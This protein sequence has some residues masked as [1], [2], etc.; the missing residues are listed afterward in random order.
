[1]KEKTEV[2]V[3][4]SGEVVN[5][6]VKDFIRGNG[7][8]DILYNKLSA[9]NCNEC[10]REMMIDD[11]CHGFVRNHNNWLDNTLAS[12]FS[13]DLYSFKEVFKKDYKVLAKHMEGQIE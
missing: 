11:F 6:E 4:E 9:F 7:L 8:V 1:M 3:T 10:E 2:Y 5:L 13:L 12:E